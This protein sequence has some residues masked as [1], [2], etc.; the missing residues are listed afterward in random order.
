MSLDFLHVREKYIFK[1]FKPLL[2]PVS[3]LQLKS[4]LN[5]PLTSQKTD[6]HT[7]FSL[8]GSLTLCLH[9]QVG[10]EALRSSLVILTLD[11]SSQGMEHPWLS[12][13]SNKAFMGTG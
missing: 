9:Y 3:V 11:D 7:P 1:L 5:D 4:I 10:Q 13:P 12:T 2:F 6:S 8:P